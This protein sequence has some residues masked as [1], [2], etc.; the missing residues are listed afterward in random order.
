MDQQFNGASSWGLL[1]LL[2]SRLLSSPLSTLLLRLEI[3]YECVVALLPLQCPRL[4]PAWTP[5]NVATHTMFVA[6]HTSRNL[7]QAWR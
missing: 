4:E 7:V 2:Y 5:N 1:A 6:R 3:N